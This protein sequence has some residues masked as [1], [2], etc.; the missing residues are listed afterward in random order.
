MN[1]FNWFSTWTTAI[2][3]LN[4]DRQK[5][6]FTHLTEPVREY[7]AVYVYTK[8]WWDSMMVVLDSS[9]FANKI[10]IDKSDVY[11]DIAYEWILFSL[12]F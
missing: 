12:I 11:E 8:L 9:A 4:Q 6:L 7:I 5:H 10:C 2:F 1:L 3:R